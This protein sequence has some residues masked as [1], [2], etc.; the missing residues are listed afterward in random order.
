MLFVSSCAA[1]YLS[2]YTEMKY[3]GLSYQ[4]SMERDAKLSKKYIYYKDS[5]LSRLTDLAQVVKVAKETA[6]ATHRH[7]ILG[8]RLFLAGLH[9]EAKIYGEE[10]IRVLKK[11]K[12]FK[13]SKADIKL[14]LETYVNEKYEILKI[15]RNKNLCIGIEYIN[16][17]G[18]IL[19]NNNYKL[20]LDTAKVKDIRIT[21]NS[22]Y[23]FYSH[24]DSGYSAPHARVCT[25][26]KFKFDLPITLTFIDKTLA[27]NNT[28]EVVWR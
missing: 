2:H 15:D 21:V 16:Q 11:A 3:K 27:T 9:T 8:E 14:K 23:L 24:R 17:E 5:K 19:R 22:D 10:K 6:K 25:V 28:F 1:P 7:Q 18:Y 4:A 12:E 26:E 13:W 20:R